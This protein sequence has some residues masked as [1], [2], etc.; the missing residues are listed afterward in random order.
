MKQFLKE[1]KP[2]LFI[3]ALLL[4]LGIAGAVHNIL[5]NGATPESR[6]RLAFQHLDRE[7]VQFIEE[8]PIAAGGFILWF[9]EENGQKGVA[10]FTQ[11]KEDFYYFSGYRLNDGGQ[12]SMLNLS[13]MDYGSYDVL[14]FDRDDL[15]Y[16][17]Y[18]VYSNDVLWK[19]ERIPAEPLMVIEM[20]ESNSVRA[21][22][23]YYDR[24]GN[25]Y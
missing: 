23:T 1:T 14:L 5:Y 17:E 12:P 19:S 22:F 8:C 25:R 11:T 13:D 20:P 9:Y 2:A 18:E 16:L 21:T 4:L 6:Q 7:Q 3:T 10:T 24:E 15:A